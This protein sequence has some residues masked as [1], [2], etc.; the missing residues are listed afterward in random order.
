MAYSL[1]PLH[2]GQQL[3]QDVLDFDIAV[4]QWFPNTVVALPLAEAILVPL[5]LHRDGPGLGWQSC[6]GLQEGSGRT[7]CTPF[8]GIVC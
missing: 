4:P 3:L 1:A 8:F 6:A 7:F 5:L 2:I